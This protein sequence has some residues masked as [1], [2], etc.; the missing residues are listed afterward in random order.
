MAET[1]KKTILENATYLFVG[2]VV[3]RLFTA[4]ATIFVA[5][6]LGAEQ[7]GALSVGLA[8]GAVAGYF[9]D[10][11][12]TH[13]LI[14]EGTKPNSDI[15]SL[16]GGAFKLRILFAATT[17]VVS[18]FLIY[19]LYSDPVLRSIVYFIVLPTIWGG[20]LQGVGVAYFQMI[21][22]MQ[23]VAFIRILSGAATT[24][25][26]LTGV[27]LG[28]PVQPLAL[29]YGLSSLVGGIISTGMVMRR[30]PSIKG[31]HTGLL[32]GLFAFTVGGLVAMLLPQMGPLVLERVATLQEVGYFSAVY[33]IPGLLYQIP[34]T[35]A[36]AF[37]PRLFRVGAV[38]PIEHVKLSGREL[39]F[40]S[41]IGG[42]LAL[43]FAL[44]PD[45]VIRI[46][47]GTDWVEGGSQILAILVWV[48]VLQSINYPLADALTTKGLQARRTA[49][50]IVA[51]LLGILS[52][53][54][55][56]SRLGALGGAVAAMIVEGVLFLGYT[57]SN[58]Q[59]W[60]ILKIGL[61]GSL[62]ALFL[63]FFIIL[64]LKPLITHAWL[65]I[66]LTFFLYTALIITIDDDVKIEIKHV[67]S[68][69]NGKLA[70]FKKGD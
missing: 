54:T 27:Y 2:N 24:L 46:L 16:L 68:I 43:P 61:P 6:Y 1:V 35:L 11:G 66:I 29:G 36:A 7:Y 52:Y 58:P 34:G 37:Y 64:F 41:I 44:Y 56:G 70:V 38:N 12:L 53:I 47:F 10:L 18:V 23:Y 14:R 17:T 48:V 26:L 5:R 40:M 57:I 69:L 63:T 32:N 60:C 28:W 9:T 31:F 65:G 45:V 15:K 39:K 4:L 51:G 19:L 3:V 50:L 20:A 30:V 67:Y 13:T 59:G 33:R 25:F 8:F 62:T 21:E 22:E 49:V 42:G 55:L